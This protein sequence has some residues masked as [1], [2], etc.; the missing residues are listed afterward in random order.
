MTDTARTL[1]V[2]MIQTPPYARMFEKIPLS[3]FHKGS[4]IDVAVV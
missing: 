4:G 1:V 3:V 2:G